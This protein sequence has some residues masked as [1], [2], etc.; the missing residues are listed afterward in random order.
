[1]LPSTAQTDLGTF[2]PLLIGNTS[3]GWAN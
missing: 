2:G 3:L 1:M